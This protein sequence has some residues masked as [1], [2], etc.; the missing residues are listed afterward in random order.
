[1]PT[2]I[3]IFDPF[4]YFEMTVVLN[5]CKK[6]LT[7]SGGLQ[8]EAYWSKKP[9]VTLRSETEW[10]ET[11]HHNWNVLTGIHSNDII[12][13]VNREVEETSWTPLYG[14]GDTS[15]RIAKIFKDDIVAA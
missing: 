15:E 2:N 13:A 1:L 7:D 6:V 12:E 4:S 9:C 11:L 8:K 3:H 10:V 14:S 5:G